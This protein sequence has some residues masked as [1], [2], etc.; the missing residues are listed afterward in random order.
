MALR[1][2]ND[3]NLVALKVT[4]RTRGNE[5][6][7]NLALEITE[8]HDP[9]TVWSAEFDA[10]QLGVSPR[11]GASGTMLSEFRL[12]EGVADELQLAVA[13]LFVGDSRAPRFVGDGEFPWC[14]EHRASLVEVRPIDDVVLLRYALSADAR[15]ACAGVVP[16]AKVVIPRTSVMHA[17]LVAKIIPTATS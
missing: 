12:P 13:P 6:T 2:K 15:E 5:A 1:L 3:H 16:E 8:H 10:A 17:T 4:L 7:I 11:P 14:D 9:I